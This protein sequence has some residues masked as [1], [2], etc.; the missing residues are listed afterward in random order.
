MGGQGE[1]HEDPRIAVGKWH[2]QTRVI[3]IHGYKKKKKR[4]EQSSK[5][6]KTSLLNRIQYTHTK[7]GDSY[8]GG[9]GGFSEAIHEKKKK[10][11]SSLSLFLPRPQPSG[12][13]QSMN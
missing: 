6:N 2:R 11:E 13:W 1:A 12:L 4:Q 5:S 7:K 9:K 10:K 8:T 3:L